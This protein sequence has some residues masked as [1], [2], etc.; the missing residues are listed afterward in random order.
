MDEE[1]LGDVPA[2]DRPGDDVLGHA[3]ADGGPA[4]RSSSAWSYSRL[5]PSLS[6]V[7]VSVGM[8]VTRYLLGVGRGVDARRVLRAGRARRWAGA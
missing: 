4:A 5:P 6:R 3:H 7:T 2:G 1:L 8:L